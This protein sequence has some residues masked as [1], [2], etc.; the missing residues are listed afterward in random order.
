MLLDFLSS[1]IDSFFLTSVDS[2]HSIFN[3]KFLT[4]IV[5]LILWD[6]EDDDEGFLSNFLFPEL[7]DEQLLVAVDVPEHEVPKSRSG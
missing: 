7:D 6:C 1:K 4:F 5:S 3:I 2:L